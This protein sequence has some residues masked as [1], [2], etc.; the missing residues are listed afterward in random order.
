M[1][2]L[3]AERLAAFTVLPDRQLAHIP[4]KVQ[5]SDDLKVDLVA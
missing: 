3:W 4:S 2:S 5:C 1:F